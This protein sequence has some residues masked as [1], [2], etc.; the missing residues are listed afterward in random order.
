MNKCVKCGTEYEGNFCPNGCT[1]QPTAAG[2]PQYSPPKAKSKNVLSYIII[3][4]LAVNIVLSGVTL[5][6]QFWGAGSSVMSAEDQL[7]E[8]RLMDE[9]R[10]KI[11]KNIEV[12]GESIETNK[13]GSDKLI[14]YVK[15]TTNKDMENVWVYYDFYDDNGNYIDQATGLIDKLPAGSKLKFSIYVPDNMNGGSYDLDIVKAVYTNY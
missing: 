4:M 9:Y 8:S 6:S 3:V 15:N 7:K 13:Y 11:G 10:I 5:T 1:V 2:I 14:G 12:S